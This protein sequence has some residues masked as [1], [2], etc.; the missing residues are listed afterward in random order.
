MIRKE[1][2]RA[3]E[4]VLSTTKDIWM[5]K[6]LSNS[7]DIKLKMHT[8]TGNENEIILLVNP[9]T[10]KEGN[11]A[12]DLDDNNKSRDTKTSGYTNEN[13]KPINSKLDKKNKKVIKN[14]DKNKETENVKSKLKLKKK[15]EGNYD[16][17]NTVKKQGTN[18]TK[19]SRKNARRRESENDFLPGEDEDIYLSN[20]ISVQELA[21]KICVS[22]T[23]IIRTLFLDGVIVNINQILDIETAISIGSKLGI[24]ITPSEEEVETIRNKFSHS[25][26]IEKT[27]KRP[28]IITIMGHVD[29]GKTT[30][31]DKIRQTQIAQKEAGGITQKIGAY[32]VEIKHQNEKRKLVFLDTPGHEAFSSMRYRG[33]QVT[34][35][36]ILVVAADDG[37]KP[38]TVETIKCIKDANVPLIVAINKIDKDGANI[39]NI[40]QELTT[41]NVISDDW[42]GETPMIPISAK[43]GTNVDELLEMI[44]LVSEM[45]N[46]RASNTENARGTV[47]EAKLDK[48]KGAIATLLVQN[49]MLEVGDIIVT[50]QHMAKIRGMI[51]SDNI[52]VTTSLPSSPVLVWGLSDLPNI[53]DNFEAFK[54]EKIA[55]SALQ[56]RKD[57]IHKKRKVSSTSDTYSLSSSNIKAV[58]NLVIKTD[59]QGSV[60]AIVSSINQIDQEKVK[61]RILYASPGEIT[62]TDVDFADASKSIILAFNT[63]LAPG[64]KKIARHLSVTVKEYDVIYDLFDDIQLMVDDI[65]GPQYEERNI[66][67]AIVK[68]VFPLG[69]NYV[70]GSLVTEG[71]IIKG[72]HIKVSRGE[73]Q[74]YEGILSS[75][76][77]LKQDVREIE[78]DSECG[79]YIEE[80]NDWEE[81][82]TILAFELIE[83]KRNK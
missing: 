4:F 3:K 78:Q 53:G 73:T 47:L 42:G 33:V 49:G 16:D 66:G 82:D 75:L 27:E 45:L 62:E 64:A 59:I 44:V 39:E 22:E 65:I 1:Y 54:D 51:N 18:N 31:L 36:A 13:D 12:Y 28:P 83:K 61:I 60:E 29:H 38:Q 8:K 68:T 80:F 5:S 24:E 48:S 21:E 14:D 43:E 40:K 20:P 72:C 63:T 35:I 25:D 17:S 74:V 46:L 37:V 69:K 71:K 70:A 2:R 34:D 81:N 52:A 30:L 11:G 7:N 77:Q 57:E 23:D 15:I 10:I 50:D 76:K 67:R 6:I 56:V 26:D 79:I 55:K 9:I 58:I 19:K 32:E 41:Y